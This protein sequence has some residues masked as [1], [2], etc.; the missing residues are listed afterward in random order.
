MACFG[1]QLP[2]GLVRLEPASLAEAAADA[3]GRLVEVVGHWEPLFLL[4]TLPP[5]RGRPGQLGGQIQA[6]QRG[7]DRRDAIK[8]VGTFGREPI[9]PDIAAM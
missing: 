8:G 1:V 3:G 6:V 5:A 4:I 2:P 9:V 7:R